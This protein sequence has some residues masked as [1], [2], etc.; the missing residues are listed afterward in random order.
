MRTMSRLVGA[1]AISALFAVGDSGVYA[2]DASPSGGTAASPSGEVASPS[3][4]PGGPYDQSLV[5][6]CA[7]GETKGPKGE[8]GVPPSDLSVS[9][10]EA[11]TLK[12]GGYKAALLWPISGDF[13]TALSQG[14]RHQ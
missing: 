9:A 5:S 11:A 6:G 2:Q 12:A 14:L 3:I 4:V 10:D 1:L 8:S 7:Q 13:T